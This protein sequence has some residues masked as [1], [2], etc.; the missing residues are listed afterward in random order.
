MTAQE[1][2]VI[3]K[4]EIEAYELQRSELIATEKALR[5]GAYSDS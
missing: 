5:H 2:M 1:K 3:S 4:Q